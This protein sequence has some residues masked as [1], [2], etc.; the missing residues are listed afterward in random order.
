MLYCDMRNDNRYQN[1]KA[2]RDQRFY[3]FCGEKGIRTLDTL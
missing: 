1:I 3:I 2:L